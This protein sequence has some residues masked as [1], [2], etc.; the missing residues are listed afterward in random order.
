MSNAISLLFLLQIVFSGPYREEGN[1]GASR[2][3]V[4]TNP[5]DHTTRKITVLFMFDR[6]KIGLLPAFK[7][8]K[9]SPGASA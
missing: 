2:P 4:S 9:S 8:K 1:K 5:H 3:L 7:L 6:V